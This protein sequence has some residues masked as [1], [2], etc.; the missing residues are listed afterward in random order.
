MV[1]EGQSKQYKQKERKTRG[2]K[3]KIPNWLEGKERI[4]SAPK[5]LFPTDTKCYKAGKI[6]IFFNRD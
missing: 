4:P 2:M 5:N 3:K 1:R 6:V